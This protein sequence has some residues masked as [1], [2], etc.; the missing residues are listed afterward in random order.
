LGVIN[1]SGYSGAGG[2]VTGAAIKA[3]SSGTIA[4]T[5]VPASLSFWTGTD[6]APTVLTERLNI[7][8]AGAFDFK[9]GAASNFKLGNAMD[10]NQ[11]T[12][13][14]AQSIG[15]A[16]FSLDVSLGGTLDLADNAVG[17]PTGN[18]INFSGLLLIT[19]T[20]TG[21]NAMFLTGGAVMV[22]VA[23]TGAE[24]TVTKNTDTKTNVYVE[25]TIVKIQNMVGSTSNYHVMSFRTRSSQ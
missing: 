19:N 13:L 11:Q 18:A 20:A 8:N 2:Y 17:T 3:I 4:T 24:F 12:I 21:Q 1:F 9:S 14:S 23:Q 6:A 7:S 5:R 15:T 22:L 16:V 25:D 10:A